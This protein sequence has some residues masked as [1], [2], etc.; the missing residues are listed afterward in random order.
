MIAILFGSFLA[1][2]HGWG[3]IGAVVGEGF[4]SVVTMTVYRAIAYKRRGGVFD[5]RSPNY[6]P[7]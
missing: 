6:R 1:G 3:W 5:M 2:V 4:A 7:W